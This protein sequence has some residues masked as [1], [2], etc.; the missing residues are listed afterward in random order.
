MRGP[1]HWSQ[2]GFT[3]IETVIASA[4]TVLVLASAL[5]LFL[6]YQTAHHDLGVRMEANR[7]ASMALSRMVYGVG[8]TNAGLR[9]AGDVALTPGGDGWTLQVQDLDGNGAGTFR[10]AASTSNLWF[11]PPGGDETVFAQSVAAT[12][13]VESNALH[14]SVRAGVQRGRFAATQELNTAIRWRN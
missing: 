7:R 11:A 3:L 10:Y 6:A 8:G 5:G 4:M 12:A 13:L 9:A 14:L 2:A 1:G